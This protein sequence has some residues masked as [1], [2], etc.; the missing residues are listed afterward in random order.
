MKKPDRYSSRNLI[1]LY[2]ASFL[3]QLGTAMT[4]SYVPLYARDLGAALA[5]IGAIETIRSLG[6]MAVNL[7]GGFLAERHGIFRIIEGIAKRSKSVINIQKTLHNY[8]RPVS[9]IKSSLEKRRLIIIH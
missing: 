4:I 2:T 5:L 6:G 8:T 1:L 3:V 7:P 9:S